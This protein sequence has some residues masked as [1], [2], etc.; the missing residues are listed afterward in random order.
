MLN[1]SIL[2]AMRLICVGGDVLSIH[3]YY[4]DPFH[5]IFHFAQRDA[6]CENTLNATCA[7]SSSRAYYKILKYSRDTRNFISFDW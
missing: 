5:R 4:Y 7:A 6:R 3:K 1:L 2:L